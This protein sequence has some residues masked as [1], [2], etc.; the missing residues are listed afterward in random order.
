MARLQ[1]H[2]DY[3]TIWSSWEQRVPQE[4]GEQRDIAVARMYDASEKI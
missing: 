4:E 1:D 3:H 2:S